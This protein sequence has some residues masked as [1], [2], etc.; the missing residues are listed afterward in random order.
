MTSLRTTAR[1][2]PVLGLIGA[3]PARHLRRRHAV[4][5]LDPGVGAVRTTDP[6][7]RG[8]G[9]VAGGVYLVVKGFRPSPVTVGSAGTGRVPVSTGRSD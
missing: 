1:V 7:D 9:A 6:P 2:V 4:R 5:L 3:P 8:V